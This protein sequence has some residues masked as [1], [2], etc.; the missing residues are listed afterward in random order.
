M[1]LPSRLR[2]L[3]AS[4]LLLPVLGTAQPSPLQTVPAVDLD[5]YAG[6]WREIASIPAFFQRKCAR[7]TTASYARGDAGQVIVNN[8][9]TRED[10][11]VEAAEG[12]ARIV[13]GSNNA[14]LE[15]SF[16]RLFGDYRFWLAGDYW[17]VALDD[18][19]RWVMV[20]TPSRKYGWVLA[21]EPQLT[22]LEQSRVLAAMGAAGYDVCAFLVTPQTGG[23]AKREPLCEA[24]RAP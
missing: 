7:D 16:M 19:Y 11:G 6:D 15:V 2:L 13:P 21:R 22:A 23:A 8:R 9:C 5:R 24:V 18:D 14:K 12:R 1:T 4:L 17:V 10:G 3:F 20:G